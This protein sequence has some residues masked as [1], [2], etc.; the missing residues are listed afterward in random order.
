[1][2]HIFIINNAAGKE[3]LAD[4]IRQHLKKRKDIKYFAF[5]T[6]EAGEESTIAAKVAKYFDGERL[7]FYACGGS[8]TF[9]NMINGISDLANSEV[10]FFPC[11]LTN[12]F[13]KSFDENEA[14]FHDLDNLIDGRCQP[15][16]YIKTNHGIAVNSVSYG[17]DS[18]LIHYIDALRVFDIFGSQIPYI[19][20]LLVGVVSSVP[21]K[22]ILNIDDDETMLDYSELIFTNGCFLGGNLRTTPHAN[23]TDGKAS[24]YVT[25]DKKGPKLLP[26]L[27]AL[28]KANFKKLNRLGSLGEASHFE[29]CSAD[30]TS[31][32]MNLDGELVDGG[33][34]W[35]IDIINKGLNFVMPKNFDFKAY[36]LETEG[37]YHG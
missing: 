33:R 11:G 14:F 7:R 31:V 36:K 13:L 29:I 25:V 28:M 15:I 3:H 8:G 12:D 4:G 30:G 1:M 5:N 32:I 6:V 21:R 2:I 26:D 9:R 20:A 19:L 17:I 34:F 22:L 18:R 35:S 37:N 24:Y 27:F 16:D 10:A 23:I